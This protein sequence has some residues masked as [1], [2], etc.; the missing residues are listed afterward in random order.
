MKLSYCDICQSLIK[1]G[2][3]KFLFALNSVTEKQ[4]D[5]RME[6]LSSE[7]LKKVI[8]SYQNEYKPIQVFEICKECK[9]VIQRLLELRRQ[10]IKKI[11]DELEK[12]WGNRE[13]ENPTII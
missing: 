10:E 3:K 11:K 12:A 7:E 13:D 1:Q 5:D 4:D 6:N 2:E 8:Q 9:D